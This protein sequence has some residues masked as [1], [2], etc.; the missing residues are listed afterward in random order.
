VNELRAEMLRAALLEREL[1]R[2]K[3]DALAQQHTELA[4]DV[5]LV[6]A[7]AQRSEAEQQ[8]LVEH[9]G[10]IARLAKAQAAA[11][12]PE[13]WEPLRLEAM[14]FA[15]VMAAASIGALAV[16]VLGLVLCIMAWQRWRAG[17]LVPRAPVVERG[18]AGCLVEG[19][20]IYLCGF[21]AVMAWL[22]RS[23]PQIPREAFY[24]LAL[25]SVIAGLLW[26]RWRGMPRAAWREALGLHRGEGWWREA[27]HGVLG[28]IAGLPLLGLGVLA[29]SLIVR[30][31]GQTPS[32]PIMEGIAN[33]SVPVLVLTLLAV[34]WAPLTEEA[35]FR[36]LL[37]P[38][39]SAFM[40]WLVGGLVGAFV[41][42][43]IHPQGWAGV[44]PIMALALTLSA[45]RLTRGSLVAPMT[46]HALN[47]GLVMLML[48]LAY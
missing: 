20:A 29:S 39:L 9:H 31:T 43:V 8:Q 26:P 22:A 42:A 34:V 11:W 32:H 5:R 28:W 46:A 19:F 44:P 17:L 12:Q 10:W 2:A 23:L 40:R 27:W 35:M 13:A 18:W 38:G 16:G 30:A 41:F 21:T 24:G 1:E 45:L 7:G 25:F 48:V 37:F 4:E 3:L 36:G 33:G 6:L 14:R 15:G 47:N